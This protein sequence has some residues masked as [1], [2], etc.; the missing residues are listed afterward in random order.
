MSSTNDD[1]E[2]SSN[3]RS[4]SATSSSHQRVSPAI[5]RTGSGLTVDSGAEPLSTGRSPARRSTGSGI[6][7]VRHITSPLVERSTAVGHHSTATDS[8]H[9]SDHFNLYA[10]HCAAL[11]ISPAV[12]VDVAV[13][14][15]FTT[16]CLVL[17]GVSIGARG[18]TALCRTIVEGYTRSVV[19]PALVDGVSPSRRSASVD[20]TSAA[21]APTD[22][23]APLRSVVVANCYLG[24]AGCVELCAC[25]A[26]LYATSPS[27]AGGQV[28][29]EL[30]LSGNA[31]RDAN[32]LVDLVKRCSAA[33]DHLR[34]LNL[35]WNK[36]GN[37]AATL[38]LLLLQLRQCPEFRTLNLSNNLLASTTVDG[39]TALV[40][41]S[42]TL[43]AL[44]VSWNSL[45]A[46]AGTALV[47]ALQRSNSLTAMD[48]AGNG[49]QRPDLE[50]IATR[51]IANDRTQAAAAGARLLAR[52]TE[53]K[54]A[55]MT[56]EIV[57]LR[58]ALADSE[59]IARDHQR[60]VDTLRAQAHA[61]EA[62]ADR[63]QREAD[64]RLARLQQQYENALASAADARK[65]AMEQAA[66]ASARVVAACARADNQRI[67]TDAAVEALR[68]EL[69]SVK[70]E[71]AAAE[72]ELSKLRAAAA[73]KDV[74]ADTLKGDLERAR[75]DITELKARQTE[76]ETSKVTMEQRVSRLTADLNAAKEEVS[77]LREKHIHATATSASF[78]SR[79]RDLES[80]LESARKDRD[81][82]AEAL[83][84]THQQAVRQTQADH[85]RA[86]RRVTDELAALQRRYDDGRD[87]L[88]K[89]TDQLNEA[90]TSLDAAKSSVAK[91]DADHADLQM[92]HAHEVSLLRADIARAEAARAAADGRVQSVQ[93]ESMRQ[94]DEHGRRLAA[95]IDELGEANRR[96]ADRDTADGDGGGARAQ[97]AALQ[98]E[99]SEA[100]DANRK[101]Q[102][103]MRHQ[104]REMEQ[105]LLEGVKAAMRSTSGGSAGADES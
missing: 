73:A 38:K 13:R 8:A 66:E 95:V 6:P 43:Q 99:L 54:L 46:T 50:T 51:L 96:R 14:A 80:E 19:V 49:L 32:P 76:W 17:R 5:N 21:Q 86:L 64:E 77:S 103:K 26:A 72:S 92:K 40:A 18:L 41:D 59:A 11:G 98:R 104:A 82:A 42:P 58:D 81:R 61:A 33:S 1:F 93:Q 53:Q 34:L 105:R 47:A 68:R 52:E 7:E 9:A 22:S 35:E 71:L 74:N 102:S 69:G 67:E 75:R 23:V 10:R 48:V 55:T 3:H 31:I 12:A 56:R 85:E 29:V 36:L 78:E 89:L 63:T 88:R 91:R 24:D 84:Q 37:C 94:L 16:G 15:G 97:M 60:N 100:K 25:L 28:L 101:L 39:I 45:G 27:A 4:T 2:D 90:L 20:H 30:D 44:N 79:V 62:R 57:S 87:E 65:Q 70:S 83:S